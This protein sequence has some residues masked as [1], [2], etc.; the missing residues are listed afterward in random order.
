MTMLIDVHGAFWIPSM[1]S[2]SL[3]LAKANAGR[4]HEISSAF[5][6]TKIAPAMARAAVH[7]PVLTVRMLNLSRI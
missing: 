3:V 6:L 2:Y 4:A 5:V 1:A 7:S